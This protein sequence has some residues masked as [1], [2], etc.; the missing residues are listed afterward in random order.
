MML[1]VGMKFEVGK[2]YE[3][4]DPGLEPISVL[5]RTERMIKVTNSFGPWRMLIRHDI[6]GDEMVIDSSVPEPFRGAF[7]CNARWEV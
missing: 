5:K 7:T 1:N 4:N 6:D 3:W 2:S